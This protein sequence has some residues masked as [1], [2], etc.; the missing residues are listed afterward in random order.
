MIADCRRIQFFKV[1]AKYLTQILG[2]MLGTG[3]SPSPGT[4]LE[5]RTYLCQLV[6]ELKHQSRVTIFLSFSMS[7]KDTSEVVSLVYIAR[8]C[9]VRTFEHATRC[10]SSTL[11]CKKNVSSMRITGLSSF[12]VA[13]YWCLEQIVENQCQGWTNTL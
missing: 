8:Q 9:I 5:Q 13:M 2:L 6:K 10:T 11:M 12:L 7:V 1:L 4:V 3:S